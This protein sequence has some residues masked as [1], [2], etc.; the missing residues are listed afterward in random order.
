MTIPA[1]VEAAWRFAK[2]LDEPE[3]QAKWAQTGYIPIRQSAIDTPEVQQLWTTQ[4]YYKVAFDQLASDNTTVAA[5]G[6]V[7]GDFAGV[8]KA[9]TDA[10]EQ[11]MTNGVA[12][13]DALAEAAKNANSAISD[14]N[15]SAGG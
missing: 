5:K 1:K 12:P 7:I 15:A 8:R 4:P 6:P 2:Y 9:E 3:T 14:Y 13:A 10:M 11:M